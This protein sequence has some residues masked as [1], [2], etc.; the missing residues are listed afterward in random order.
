MPVAPAPQGIVNGPTIS[1]PGLS[2]NI[3][4][5]PAGVSTG[6]GLTQPSRLGGPKPAAVPQAP[7]PAPAVQPQ[8]KTQFLHAVH[9]SACKVFGTVLG[10]EANKAHKN[11]FHVDLAERIKDT[12]ICD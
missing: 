6:F 5:T 4:G 11:H 9:R 7:P 2:I 10:P 12:K 1:I 3:G 8:A